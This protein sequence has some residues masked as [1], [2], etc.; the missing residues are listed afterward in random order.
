MFSDD[1][2]FWPFAAV[3]LGALSF[4]KGVRVPSRYNAT[5]ALIDYRSGLVKRGFFGATAGHWWHLESFS[6]FVEISYLLLFAMFCMCE[7]VR[8]GAWVWESRSRF[9]RPALP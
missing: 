5:Q 6:N 3:F 4:A 1:R 9:S 2:L 7:V 8:L